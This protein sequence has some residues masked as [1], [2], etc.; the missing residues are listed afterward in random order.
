MSR[1]PY[2]A[3]TATMALLRSLH[4]A[5]SSSYRVLF[6]DSLSSHDALH[7]LSRSS[8]CIHCAHRVCT[9]LTACLR[10]KDIS[11]TIVQFP[12]KCHGGPQRLHNDPCV[13]VQSSYSFVGDLTARQW[14]PHCALFEC[15][16]KA[17][18][19]VCFEHAQSSG[20][21]SAFYVIPQR[22][23][24][25]PLRCCGDACDRTAGI[26]AFYIFLG[27]REVAVRTLLWCERGFTPF[28]IRCYSI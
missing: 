25:I 2:S 18:H 23:L 24:A 27:R 5:L 20:R 7:A 10:C 6:G 3:L 11:K 28:G 8:Q 17:S 22:L 26:S 16:G 9:A 12:Y 15:C 1:G 19:G 13:R 21:R 4:G 14:R